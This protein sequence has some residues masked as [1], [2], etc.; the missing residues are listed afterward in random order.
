[1]ALTEIPSELSSTPSIVDGGNATAITIDSS[2]NVGI[3]VSPSTKLHVL[4]GRS[5]FYSGDNYAVGVG[6]ASGVL[7]GYMGS[8]AVNVLSF[9]EPGGVER[10]RIDASGNVGVGTSNATPSNGEGLC[11]GS[12]STITR[13]DMR[14]TTTGDATGDGTS[15]QLNGNNFTIENREAGY[16]AFATSLTERMR[17]DSSGNVGI[18]SSSPSGLAKTLN[19]DGGSGGSSLALDGGDNFAVMYT[20]A[21]VGD[22]TS[23]FSNTG[24]KFA[25]ATS[26]AAAGFAE[27]MRIDSSGNVGIGTSSPVSKLDIASGDV[28]ISNSSNAPF[29]NFVDNT[30]RSQ[31]L[32]RIAMDQLSGTAGQLLFSTTT[33]GTLSERMRIDS[34]GNVGIGSNPIGGARLGLSKSAG[35]D[36]FILTDTSSADLIV[37]CTSG[38]TTIKSSTGTLALG[39]GNVEKMRIDASGNVGI[40]GVGNISPY[41]IRFAINGTGTG[42]AG[43]YFGSGVIIPTDNTPTITD[44]NVD[45][46]ASNY[47]FKDLY[48]S[49]GALTSTV[50]FL[51]N[52]TVSGSDA[53]IFRPADNTM[54]FSTNGAER[55]RIDASGRTG[56]FGAAANTRSDITLTTGTSDSSKRWGFGGGATGNNAVFYVINESNVGVYLGHGAQ[57]WTAHSDERIK[58]NITSVG[59]VLPSLMN[60]RCVKFNLISNPAVTKIGFIAQ[61]WESAF[62]EVV[63]ENEHLV[64]EADGTIGTED[65]SDSTT[66]VKAMAYTETIPLLLKAI[67][68]QQA[69]IE[70]LTQRIQTL[71][72]N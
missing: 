2:E 25:T 8:P 36:V 20:G 71:E 48:L 9:S 57:G 44:A 50:K 42:G 39:T 21:T 3:G 31:S 23:I 64:L 7:G 32:A 13:I 11:I 67:Q 49:G 55:M 17:I 30:T 63:D 5:T 27:R 35:G 46:G 41:G 4:G 61:D 69:T 59:T 19:I 40:G 29:I 43:L 6:N 38:V 15:L 66:P 52:T 37:N 72:N 28:T 10:M 22:P 68:E 16:V 33:G 60:M 58:E 24:F 45:L 54:A 18:G 47:R 12:G 62:P 65:D 51:A 56:F 26:K 53:T 14:N 1:M 34:S 70:A